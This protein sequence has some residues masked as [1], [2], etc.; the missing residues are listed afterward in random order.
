MTAFRS[1]AGAPAEAAVEVR[2]FDERAA[3]E[4]RLH[5]R[6]CPATYEDDGYRLVCSTPHEPAL[7]ITDYAERR[8]SPDHAVEGLFRYWRWLPARRISDRVPGPIAYRSEGLA[9]V[10]GVRD[11]WICFSGFWPS[12]G[13][14]LETTTFKELEAWVVL[15]R[16]PADHRDVL[17][18]ASAG[19]TAAAFAHVCSQA[20]VPCLIIAPK[21]AL[22]QLRFTQPIGDGVKFVGLSGDA[23]YYDAIQV[24]ERVSELD[25]F[26]AEGG[27]RNVARRDALAVPYLAAVEAAGRLPDF[28]FQAVGSGAGAIATQ[29]ATTR[30]IADGRFGDTR[31]HL[32]LSQNEPFCP[33]YRSWSAGMRELW[34]IDRD[35]TKMR[36]RELIAP[37]LSH[38][39][40]PYAIRGGV[41]DA[42]VATDG[43]V[44]VAANDEVVSAQRLFLKA[45]GVDINPAAGVATVSLIK[46]VRE[47][48]V[49]PDA[50]IMLNITGGGR[51]QLVASQGLVPGDLSLDIDAAE[52]AQ[53]DTLRRLRALF[54]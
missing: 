29:D 26:A 53:D 43:D 8:F 33:I 12:A 9:R 4:Y 10:L 30:M 49:D 47:R 7:L 11:L 28:Y 32:M 44:F 35:L 50:T 41:Y 23:D 5:C 48:H 20:G 19:N 1:T 6:A 54:A 15:S 14:R 13:A 38:P 39:R 21:P 46:A 37:V 31:P 17:V 34:T 25:G 24:A 18:I 51:D 27:A 42:L 45:E 52:L 3:A 36:S 2:G 40:P 22:T 16:L